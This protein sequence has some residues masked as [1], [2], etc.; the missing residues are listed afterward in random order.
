MDEDLRRL[1]EIERA[2]F[3]WW[4]LALM[5]F[6]LGVSGMIGAVAVWTFLLWA[7]L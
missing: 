1:A 2:E 7:V 6:V 5:G 3:P 4:K